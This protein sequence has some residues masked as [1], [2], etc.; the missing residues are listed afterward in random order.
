M[1][2]LALRGLPL[3]AGWLSIAFAPTIHAIDGLKAWQARLLA[4]C[5]VGILVL[6]VLFGISGQQPGSPL[7]RLER[8]LG[9]LWPPALPLVSLVVLPYELRFVALAMSALLAVVFVGRDTCAQ[10]VDSRAWRWALMGFAACAALAFIAIGRALPGSYDND[11]AYYFGMAR[12]LVLTHRW[13]EPLVWQFLTR[14]P[15]LTHAPF[16]YWHGFSALSL[17]PAMAVFGPTHLVAGT[18]MGVVSGASVL[19]FAYL[20]SCA[21]PLESPVVQ[22]LA[23][24]LF[25]W[26]PAVVTYRFDVDT[27]GFVHLWLLAALVALAKRRLAWA[28]AFAC[29]TFLWRAE[30]ITLTILLSSSALYLAL[31]EPRC[32]AQ[33]SRVL[34]VLATL[35]LSYVGYHWF[36]FGTPAPPGALVASNLSDGLAPYYWQSQTATLPL[37]QR[38]TPEYIAGRVQV[39]G[40]TLSQAGFFPYQAL[41]FGCALL[42]AKQIGSRRRGLDAISRCL[43]FVGAAV[44]ALTNP[45][46]FASWR[47]LHTL[48]PVL[49]LAGA[50]GAESLLS[51]LSGLIER[52]THS[53]LLA[54]GC[55][56]CISACTALGLFHPLD[57]S[58]VHPAEPAFVK[59]LAAL[60]ATF[61]GEPVMTA[62][63]WFVLAYTNAPAV[64][65]PFNGE[66]AIESVLRRYAVKWLVIVNGENTLGS[67]SVTNELR[68]GARSQI[69]SIHLTIRQQC[70]FITLFHVD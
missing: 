70:S 7:L 43:L 34:L 6:G 56:A 20:I 13:E 39:A 8:A 19:L 47:S 27:V 48:L 49:V 55:T 14:A 57:L 54:R 3:I 67:A 5:A 41:W 31:V 25:I 59:E 37:S 36:V 69:G 9:L 22:L 50:Y 42:A 53:P 2:K 35:A 45:A 11:A 60:E 44:I 68:S 52:A 26:S 40:D 12:H 10:L 65:L 28:A 30:S 64:G 51:A 21:A 29:F 17:V 63:S 23:L 32:K 58:V 24:L 15:Q 38:F 4:A 18:V 66:Q 61:A 62:R 46:V 16:D 1:A 33:L